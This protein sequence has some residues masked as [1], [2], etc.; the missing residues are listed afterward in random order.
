[1]GQGAH[2]AQVLAPV[3]FR[4]HHAR[5]DGFDHE[6][7][8]RQVDQIKFEVE[9]ASELPCCQTWG[10]SD[11]FGKQRNFFFRGVPIGPVGHDFDI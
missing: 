8:D 2:S 7:M 1:M 5:R 3:A 10:R 6:L 9:P 11:V 4:E